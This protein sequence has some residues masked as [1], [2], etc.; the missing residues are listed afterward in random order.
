MN[1][2]VVGNLWRTGA[3]S[4]VVPNQSVIFHSDIKN[5]QPSQEVEVVEKPS[6]EI[7]AAEEI[8]AASTHSQ[9]GLGR[10]R[11]VVKQKKCG[12]KVRLRGIPLM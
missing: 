3:Q 7:Q 9:I 6:I 1:K 8:A 4:F 11:K 10:K 12:K 2:F 5:S